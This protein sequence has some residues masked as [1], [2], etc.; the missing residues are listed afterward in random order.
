[1][2]STTAQ[3]AERSDIDP[4]RDVFCDMNMGHNAITFTKVHA[5]ESDSNRPKF[6]LK[7]IQKF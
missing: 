4:L 6:A 1:M 2:I 5:E 3:S 7:L